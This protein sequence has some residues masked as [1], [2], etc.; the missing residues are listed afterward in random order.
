MEGNYAEIHLPFAKE[1]TIV[2]AKSTKIQ[3]LV[4][5]EY[6]RSNTLTAANVK[7]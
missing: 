1:I 2:N 4:V 5:V 7:Y 6:A 3:L